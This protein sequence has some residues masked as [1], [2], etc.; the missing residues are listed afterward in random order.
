MLTGMKVA[1]IGGDARTLEVIQHL[2]NMDAT[3]SLF[4]FDNWDCQ[5]S[6]VKRCDLHEHALQD[7]D[8][9]V[10]PITGIDEQHKIDS[11]F[12]SREL[13]LEEEFLQNIKPTAKI[14][15]GIAKPHLKQLCAKHHL[16]YVELLERDDVA[17]YNSIPTAEGAIMMAIK[18]TD[19]TIHGSNC[20]VLGFGRTGMT[21]AR[22]LQG[23]GAH[24]QVGVR[25][26][27][28]IARAY[29][30]G[31]EP[32]HVSKLSEQVMHIDLL[33]NTIPTL[34]VDAKV[35]SKMAPNT[36]IIDLASKPGGTDF[37]YAEK[38]GI[39]ALLA[40][41]LPG[42]VAP[43]SAGLILA[44]CLTSLIYEQLRERGN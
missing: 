11:L 38:R 34:I 35:I 19:I 7:I 32:F 27:E 24:V 30:M 41:G 33:F 6:G 22:T 3:V 2:A 5:Y 43:K 21:L 10:L 40:P 4:G 39:T 12:S 36:L 23:L 37:R 17:I 29:E 44:K 16:D 42:I 9:I 8:A 26:E 1:I 28:H 13:V 14:Y 15:T 31:Y 18:H 20:I 25:R